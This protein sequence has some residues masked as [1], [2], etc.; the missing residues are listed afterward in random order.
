MSLELTFMPELPPVA[1]GVTDDARQSIFWVGHVRVIDHAVRAASGMSVKLTIVSPQDQ[2]HPF[3]GQRVGGS[4]GQR[5]LARFSTAPEDGEPSPVHSG[6]V[7]LVWWQHDN[8]GQHVNLKL[9]DGPDGEG[10]NPFQMVRA[11]REG[12]DVLAAA[13][14]RIEDDETVTRRRRKRFADM[15]PVQQ[16][17]ILCRTD[18]AFQEWIMGI[19]GT[20]GIVASAGETPAE[21][22]A[23]I[24][25]VWCGVVSRSELGRP[26]RADA[27]GQWNELLTRFKNRPRD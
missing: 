4:S 11:G 12:G 24:V 9:D 20:I 14:F 8:N 1:A 5:F 16:S 23:R 19:G 25:R 27:L 26:D 15:S 13:F 22:A 2:V 10:M 17:Q 3:I 18:P 7:M 21:T 6:E